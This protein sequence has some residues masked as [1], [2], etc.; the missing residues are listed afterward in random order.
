[1]DIHWI[2]EEAIEVTK[3]G[4]EYH[5]RELLDHIHDD[6]GTVEGC[7]GCFARTCTIS[8][9]PSGMGGW[10]RMLFDGEDIETEDFMAYVG[11]L[12]QVDEGVTEFP[13]ENF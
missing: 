6:D 8:W 4:G 10:A 2:L 3:D 13:K 12:D 7:P 9:A 11:L 5:I 1:M